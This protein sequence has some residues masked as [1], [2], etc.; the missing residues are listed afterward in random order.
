M[1]PTAAVAEA[2]TSVAAPPQPQEQG[3]LLPAGVGSGRARD[4]D[5]HR[6]LFGPVDLG[7]SSAALVALVEAAGLTGRGGAGFPTARKLAAVAAGGSPGAAPVV[8]ANGA[9]GEPASSKDE[10]L[11]SYAP[12]LVLEGLQ[13]ACRAVDATDATLYVHEG[14]L[15]AVLESL[16]AQRWAY[17]I[18]AVRP[19]VVDAPARFLSGQ[20]TAVV[21]RLNGGLA[22]PTAVPPPVYVRGVGRRPTLVQN[23]ETLAH[24]ALLARHGAGWFRG[25]GTEHEPG[26]MLC[27]VG[28]AVVARGVLEAA[29]GTRIGEVLDRAGG[30]SEPLAAVLVGGYHGAWL[31]AAQALD[32]PL[33]V[34]SL[35]PLGA[36]PGA[37]VV[38]ALPASACGLT[39]TAR[40]V[41][42]L[43]DQSARQCGPCLNGLPAM[44]RTLAQLA[45]RERSRGL[46]ERVAEL[47]ALVEGRGACHHP[48]GTVRLVR[49][50]MRVFATE[51]A[52][53][54]AGA[55]TATEPRP[56]LPVPA[57]RPVAS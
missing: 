30:A 35:R 46:S 5:G 56:V 29:I 26:T 48:D 16:V 37:G 33:S 23:V 4:L 45:G 19:R 44:A 10:V 32:L 8:V 3:R 9:E 20:E 53:H 51:V 54:Q 17:G 31:P 12:H 15:V 22:L 6:D 25:V 28:G 49:T 27:T 2:P 39:E 43:A 13:L 21:S 36:T 42:Y 24:L 1:T 34:E 38:V 18:D 55:C 57:R 11:L 40:V 14:P 52:A 41:A 7:G 47:A 50:A